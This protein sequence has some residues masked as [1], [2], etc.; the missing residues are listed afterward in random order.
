VK[1]PAFLFLFICL[2][3]PLA[4]PQEQ[5]DPAS[6]MREKMQRDQMKALNKERQ[7]SLKKDMDELY[8]LASELKESVDKTDENILSLQ[9]V[10]KTERIEKL[11]RDIRKKM[12]DTY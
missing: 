7:A 11:A 4:I 5:E 12:K 6:P 1:T 10:K 8:R 2:L 9:V 3:A